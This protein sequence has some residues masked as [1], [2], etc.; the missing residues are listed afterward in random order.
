[1]PHLPEGAPDQ[2]V[3]W[4][5]EIADHDPRPGVG[6]RVDGLPDIVWGEIVPPGT[7]PYQSGSHTTT[8]PYK[9]ARY[10]LT[11]VHFQ[12]FVDAAEGAV[13]D[14]WW[15]DLPT[16]FGKDALGLPANPL[17]NHPRDTVSFN[18][19]VA[20]TRWLT[21]EYHAAGLLESDWEIR[22]PADFEWEIAAR[23]PD[24]RIYPWGN[25]YCAGHANIDEQAGGIG[26]CSLGTSTAVGVYEAGRHP[27]LNLYDLTGNVQ[28]WC[29][30]HF[31][32]L[33]EMSEGQGKINRIRGR[34]RGGSWCDDHLIAQSTT[35]DH[36]QAE[37]R[38][39]CLRLRLCAAPAE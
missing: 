27:Y 13:N 34:S 37:P 2:L 18:Q 3:E 25:E 12:A 33:D 20:Y 28:E 15:A 39:E 26:P 7:Y 24:G 36:Y 23:Y 5:R 38:V 10:P 6:V 35:R 17:A 16:K 32:D 30:R 11:V 9:L 1:M 4:G 22:L 14:A 19:A 21:A 29:F 31:P 8:F